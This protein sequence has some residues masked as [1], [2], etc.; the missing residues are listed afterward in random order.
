M[1][2]KPTVLCLASYFKGQRFLARCRREGWHVVLLTLESLLQE[3]WPRSEIDEVFAVPSFHDQAAL[4]K[5]VSFLARSRDIRRI[6]ALDD[7]DVEVGA[8]VREHLR[9]PGLNQSDA[10]YFRDKLAMRCRARELGIRIPE[11]T[12]IFQRD[13]IT[14]FLAQA[15]PPWLLKPRSQASAAGIRKLHDAGEV[16]RRIDQLGDDQSFYLLERFIS[17]DLYHVDSLVNQ[18]QVL[19]AEVNGYLRPLLDVY[20]G[21]GTYASR[22]VPRYQA[23]VSRLRDANEQ[24]LSG[25][26]LTRGASHT[27][28]LIAHDDGA[29]YLVET[30]ARVGGANTAEMV[31]AASGI[32]LWEEWARIELQADRYSLPSARLDHAG[33]VVALARQEWPDTSGFN[34]PEIVFRLKLK[35]HL[36]LVVRSA[37]PQR[38]E[39][40]LREYI[41]RISRDHLAV[42]PPADRVSH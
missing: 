6:V 12:G 25:F 3:D 17:G 42:L 33:V 7:F 34:D 8:A 15:P 32:N 30:S 24:V 1:S 36:G 14:R 31:E 2:A 4:L 16:W 10:R 26:G 18:G 13:E 5:S 28:F 27:E 23:E 9:L 37:S 29:I 22:T 39:A 40:L 21:G 20:Q 38:I 19:F 35:Q 41:E 11:F